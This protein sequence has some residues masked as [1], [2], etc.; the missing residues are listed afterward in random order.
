VAQNLIRLIRDFY[1]F[2]DDRNLKADLHYDVMMAGYSEK[3]NI[4]DAMAKINIKNDR[5]YAVD[6]EIFCDNNI[7]NNLYKLANNSSNDRNLITLSSKIKYVESIFEYLDTVDEELNKLN[8][9]ASTIFFDD[10][11]KMHQ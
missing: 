5:H 7:T 3:A 2:E 11:Y 4:R 10:Y 1:L 8:Y 9:V 6:L